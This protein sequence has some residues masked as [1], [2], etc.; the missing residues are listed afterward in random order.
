MIEP[1]EEMILA[2]CQASE[3]GGTHLWRD[4]GRDI[5]AAVLAIVERD[6]MLPCGQCWGLGLI[7]AEAFGRDADGAPEREEEAQCPDGCEIPGWLAAERNDAAD[8]ARLL[9]DAQKRIGLTSR[10]GY[11][12]AI[13][14]LR[15]VAERTGSPAASWCADYLL[16]DPDRLAP[17]LQ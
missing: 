7:P 16:A 13:A 15:D 14:V 3:D 5:V 11:E 6:L 8:D 4:P 17:P 1:T 2:A 9:A 12:T 10:K